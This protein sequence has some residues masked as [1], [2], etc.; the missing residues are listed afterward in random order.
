MFK[1]ILNL[2]VSL[3]FDII[4]HLQTLR[5]GDSAIFPS[6]MIFSSGQS[7]SENIITSGNIPPNPPRSGSIND[8]YIILQLKFKLSS[9][10]NPSIVP[11]DKVILYGILLKFQISQLQCSVRYYNIPRQI[12]REI[13]QYLTRYA[14]TPRSET[15]WRL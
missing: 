9:E 4:Y 7:P 5:S 10:K 3:T 2:V 14:W 13:L 15:M 12:H 1:V 8:N 6:V 11:R